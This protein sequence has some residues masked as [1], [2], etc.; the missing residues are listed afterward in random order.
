[1]GSKMQRSDSVSGWLSKPVKP[2]QL[3]ILLQSLIM[4]KNREAKDTD[5]LPSTQPQKGSDLAILLAE[6]NPINQKVALSMLKHLDYKADLAGNGLDVLAALDRK[7]YDV[8]LM[9][10]QMPNM[11]GLD[12]TR[13]IREKRMDRQ[14]CIIA[15]TAYALEGDREEFL[16]AGM[17]D[18]LSKPI[19]IDE[20]KL[21]LER[22]MDILELEAKA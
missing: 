2:R 14:P 7:P 5:D 21:A 19:Q 17:D 3:K 20:L 12:A 13:C 4:P 11:D 6:D 8:I 16:N 15:M 18:Y 10:I 1:M 22:C 9:D